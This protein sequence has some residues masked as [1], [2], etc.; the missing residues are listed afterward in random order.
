MTMSLHDDLLRRYATKKFD[1]A[2]KV[3]DADL[4]ELLES[5]RYSPS[6]YGLQPWHFLVVT[7]A[8]VR[9]Q[10]R[11]HSWNQPQITDA[12]HL[13]VLCA[14]TDMDGAYIERYVEKIMA[15]RSLGEE[16]VAGYKGMMLTNVLEGKSDEARRQWM[17][18]QVYIALG[19]LMSACMSKR[20]DS[21]P[22]EG[23]DRDAYDGILN[24]RSRG[25]EPVVL[26]PVGYRAD[27]DGYATLPKVRF[28]DS[29]LFETV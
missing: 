27:D 6:S 17:E 24:L 3:S 2:K 19:F 15:D 29:D 8:D 28:E 14:K 7:D 18:K 16:D 26:C 23:F 5:L 21:C 12:S 10:L 22:I 9:A 13:I 20:I 25:F 11:P 4:Q 1:A